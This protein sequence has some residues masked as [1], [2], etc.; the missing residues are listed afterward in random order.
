MASALAAGL[1]GAGG[2]ASGAAGLINSISSLLPSTQTTSFSGGTNTQTSQTKFDEKAVNRMIELMMQ[3]SEGLQATSAGEHQAGVFDSTTN[4]QLV[5]DLIARVA[6]E[7][8]ARTAPTETKVVA[9]PTQ[10]KVK[11]KKCFITTA[12][13]EHLGQPDD[14][15]ELE[16]L[17]MF[18]D[19]WLSDNYPMS[20]VEYYRTAPQ[21]VEKLL[22]REDIAIIW[23]RFNTEFIQ[24]AV[25]AIE[26]TNYSGAYLL[27]REM[28]VTALKLSGV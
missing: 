21:I 7:V 10:T 23:D 11:S 13:C 8:S 19:S 12:I 25:V 9:S 3:S 6:G 17:R 4:Q 22:Q 28:Y 14:C 5:N 16:T 15:Y 24:P 1:A 2:A 26:K 20:I 27:Y 18:R